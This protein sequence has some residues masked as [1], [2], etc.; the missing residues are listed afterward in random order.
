M[1]PADA[2]SAVESI[3]DYSNLKA[4]NANKFAARN[5]IPIPPFLLTTVNKKII[6]DNGDRKK[7]LV[8]VIK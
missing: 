3:E 1:P 8:A 6:E 7:V 4:A 2:Y 5:I